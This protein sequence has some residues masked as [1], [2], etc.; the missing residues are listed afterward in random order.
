LNKEQIETTESTKKKLYWRICGYD[1][2][3]LI[4]EKTVALGQFTEEQMKDLLRALTAKAGL[5]YAE[6]RKSTARSPQ[7]TSLS[8]PQLRRRS[9]FCSHSS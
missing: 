5:Q 1:S 6:N 8:N 3:T 9:A 7:R 4:F 2:S